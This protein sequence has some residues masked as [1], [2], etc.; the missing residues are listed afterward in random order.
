[1]EKGK[2]CNTSLFPPLLKRHRK[3]IWHLQ[4]IPSVWRPPAFLP[5]T[6]SGPLGSNTQ[7]ENSIHVEWQGTPRS[8]NNHVSLQFKRPLVCCA[9]S[10]Q[11]PLT[12][13]ACRAPLS[14]GI[15]QARILEWVAVSSSRGSSQS[16]D[17]IPALADRFFTTSTIWGKSA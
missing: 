13:R 8:Q 9:K 12:V 3:K 14:M 2:K 4:P 5:I 16:R 11:S 1:M 10:L 17:R 6:L 7:A 15:F